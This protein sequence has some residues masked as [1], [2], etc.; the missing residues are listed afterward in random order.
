VL[1]ANGNDAEALSDKTRVDSEETMRTRVCEYCGV[2]NP[3]GRSL[4]IACG[5][6]LK[7]DEKEKSKTLVDQMLAVCEDYEGFSWCHTVGAISAKR[8]ANARKAM[9]IPEEK[10][11]VMLYDETIFG[12]NRQGFAVCEDGLYWKNDWAVK[13]KRT[14]LS[15]EEFRERKIMIKGKEIWLGR[16]DKIEVAAHS[17]D[18]EKIAELLQRIHDVV[19]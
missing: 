8:M 5:A 19:A 4:C 9:H 11:V 16:G 13:T 12:S 6:V 15:W 10:T 1:K 18:K 17:Y 3:P 7:S 14:Y 2:E